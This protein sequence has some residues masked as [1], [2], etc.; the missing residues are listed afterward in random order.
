[1]IF[2]LVGERW[3]EFVLILVLMFF[4]ND[5]DFESFVFGM[6][7]LPCYH[8]KGYCNMKNVNLE[9]AKVFLEA[10]QDEMVYLDA[11]MLLETGSF[12]LL[13][14]GLGLACFLVHIDG[15]DEEIM[16]YFDKREGQE[17]MD[18]LINRPHADYIVACYMKYVADYSDEKLSDITGKIYERQGMIRRVLHERRK[19]ARKLE[20]RVKL[21]KNL[22][23]PHLLIAK[24]GRQYAITIWD[25]HAQLGYVDNIDW[26]TNKLATTK[27]IMYLCNYIFEV[28]SRY[29]RMRKRKSLVELSLDPLQDYQLTWKYNVEIPSKKK[30]ILDDLFEGGKLHMN[31]VEM[32]E[33]HQQLIDL[34]MDPSFVV[35]PEVYDR[36]SRWFDQ[37]EL[38]RRKEPISAIDFTSIKADLYPYQM[39]GAY[40]ALFRSAAIIADE[41]GLGKT[42]QAIATAL[43]KQ[44]YLGF[45]KTLIVCP[46]SVKYQWASEIEKFSDE[47]AQVITG[48]PQERRAMYLSEDHFFTIVNYEAVMRDIATINDAEFDL[49]ILDEAQ[50]IKNFNTRTAAIMQQLKKQHGLVLT[51]T[52][53]ENKLIDIYSIILFLDKYML[54][55]LWEFSYQHCVFDFE[56]A[57]KINGYYDLTSLKERLQDVVIRRQRHEVLKQLPQVSEKKYLLTLHP[58]QRSM[59]AS[60][61]QSIASILAKKFKTKFDWD[62][63]MMA[64][65][66]MRRV[67]NSTYLIQ[68]N[69]N[70]SSKLNELKYILQYQL[71]IRNSDQ[72][73][74]IFS[75]WLDSLYLIERVLDELDVKYIKLT[76]KVPVAKRGA[77]I[78][79]FTVNEA[80]KVFLSTD[81]GGTGLNLQIA[82]TV[83][84]FEIPWNPAKRNQRIGRINR[85]G[86]RK[87]NL[88]VIDLICQDSIELRI[89]SGLALKQ[90]LFD[91]VLNAENYV[92]TVDFTEEGRAQF[93]EELRTYIEEEDYTPT[94]EEAK[95][96]LEDLLK[97]EF[98]HDHTVEDEIMADLSNIV[99]ESDLPDEE[100][101]WS[102]YLNE[103]LDESPAVA[104]DMESVPVKEDKILDSQPTTSGTSDEVPVPNST[105]SEDGPTPSKA[106][107]LSSD[108]HQQMEEVLTKGMDFLAGLYQMSTGKPM[109]EGSEGKKIEIDRETGE[110]VLRFRLG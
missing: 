39:D 44:Q 61:R 101:D 5:F 26:K 21:N 48:K 97:E 52:P 69:T 18:I 72:K 20:Y 102:D 73:I 105:I 19:K 16:L 36:I 59:H 55:P 12:E 35:R 68:N 22:Y 31:L 87:N 58:R 42:I 34:S 95:S 67:S 8:S 78:D 103:M 30:A 107:P 47:T 84:N 53:I 6:D 81:A 60:Y 1:M 32:V 38:E 4:G 54:T 15:E 2:C 100:V 50:R 65:T 71:D 13:W 75:E 96:D 82:D 3:G 9:F 92:D 85:I 90:N 45:E 64:L 41:M 14:Q 24:D 108:S 98:L 46:A 49:I 110:V 79:E 33:K 93:M 56:A 104:P 86:Q 91:G 23:D 88:L 83:I 29:Q 40:F 37:Q 57:D 77:L 89:A 28:P 74:I 11:E 27:H 63:I 94:G 99:F 106:T 7:W 43:L 80:C 76:G 70:H 25:L 10:I 51:G 66:Q 17:W 109:T 62:K